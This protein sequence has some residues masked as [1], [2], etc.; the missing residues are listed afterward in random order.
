MVMTGHQGWFATTYQT[1]ERNEQVVSGLFTGYQTS[2]ELNETAPAAWN[3][4]IIQQN[5]PPFIV[6]TKF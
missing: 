6:F 4:K 2:S 5:E 1:W 3:I